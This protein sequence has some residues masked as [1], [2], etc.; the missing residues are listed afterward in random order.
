MRLSFTKD[1]KNYEADSNS[2]L[3]S[4]QPSFGLDNK[5]LRESQKY[6]TLDDD[7]RK[8]N[9]GNSQDASGSEFSKYMKVII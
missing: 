4:K 9:S 5:P 8:Y 6:R 7:E 3:G 1:E 2:Y